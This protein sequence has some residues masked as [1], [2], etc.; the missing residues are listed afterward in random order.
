MGSGA[1]LGSQSAVIL[2]QNNHWLFVVNAGSNQISTFAVGS[3]GL[4]LASVV[5][6]GGT[7]PV[8][9][10]TY[11]DWLYVLNAGGSGNIQGFMIADAGWLM[12]IAGSSQPVSNG[13]V[14]AAPGLAQVAF[15]SDGTTL[16]VTEKTTSLLDTYPVVNGVA[17]APSTHASAGA[18]PFGFAFDRHNHAVVSE[19]S[20]S[21]SSYLIDANGF[22]VIS[23][24]VVNSQVAACWIAISKN[25][26]YAYTTNA[27]S[28]TISS[29]TI[30]GDGSL[31]LLSAVAGST[32][33]GSAPVDMAFSNNGAFLYA[34]AN[35][36][37]TITMFQM[38]ADGSLNNLGAM[39]IPVGVAG[40]AAQ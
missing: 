17:G 20:G 33:A 6:S 34:L 28:G 29:Y 26:K 37:H 13:G 25:G 15:N 31:S 14:G 30:A 5:D 4:T 10:T 35:A 3:K 18:V 16:V 1:S 40:L 9:L 38:G 39:S 2:S 7:Y 23:P 12:P 22:G 24:A 36:A 21:V 19:A 11:Q 27:G 32:G 8:S